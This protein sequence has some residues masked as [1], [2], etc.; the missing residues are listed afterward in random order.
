MPVVTTN[1][2][3]HIELWTK[4]NH[5]P[6]ELFAAAGTQPVAVAMARAARA[7]R[8]DDLVRLIGNPAKYGFAKIDPYAMSFHVELWRRKPR[9]IAS[10]VGC[11]R[12]LLVARAGYFEAVKGVER[13]ILLRHGAHVLEDSDEAVDGRA[14]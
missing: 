8:P 2:I 11:A 3:F 5:K 12:N 7:A 14:P 4:V 9:G 10:M 6:I 13:P 1:L